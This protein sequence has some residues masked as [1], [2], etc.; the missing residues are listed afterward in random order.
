MHSTFFNFKNTEHILTKKVT[1]AHCSTILTLSKG[2]KVVK[3]KD[4]ILINVELRLHTIGEFNE[5]RSLGTILTFNSIS[6]LFQSAKYYTYSQQILDTI[7]LYTHIFPNL[8][9]VMGQSCRK[10]YYHTAHR[11]LKNGK[12]F[13]YSFHAILYF[14]LINAQ[15]QEVNQSID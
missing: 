14:S 9:S 10:K 12:F 4:T 11:A 8:H 3:L 13:H 15:T 6:N 7:T 5:Q 1:F 2:E